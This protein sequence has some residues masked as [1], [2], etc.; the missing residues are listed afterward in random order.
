M[1]GI[2]MKDGSANVGARPVV[3][4]GDPGID[5]RWLRRRTLGL[6]VSAGWMVVATLAIGVMTASRIGPPGWIE[7][8]E[9]EDSGTANP[10]LAALPFMPLVFLTRL[11]GLLPVDVQ[12]PFLLGMQQAWNPKIGPRLSSSTDRLRRRAA[13]TY[14]VALGTLILGLAGL[15]GGGIWAWI[16]AS[17]PASPAVPLSYADVAADRAPAGLVMVTGALEG[18]AR[19][20]ESTHLR[21]T[22]VHDEWRDMRPGAASAPTALVERIAVDVDEHGGAREFA[23]P[24][25]FGR[26]APLDDW[27]VELLRRKGFVLADRVWVLKRSISADTDGMDDGDFGVMLAL[28]GLIATCLGGTFAFAT[29]RRLGDPSFRSDRKDDHHA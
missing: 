29:R 13:T 22:T 10:L 15:A 20:I 17:R 24:G 7:A 2:R 23:R 9:L 5:D 1:S 14:R 16:E 6:T 3:R 19:W 25:L 4:P 8:W 12:R 11:A 21:T 27:H 28:A 26:V 18:D